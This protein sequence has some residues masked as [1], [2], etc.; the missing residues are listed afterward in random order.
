V[1]LSPAFAA[2]GR[3]RRFGERSLVAFERLA[4]F[5]FFAPFVFLVPFA[6]F[7]FCIYQPSANA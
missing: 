1:T 7:V 5:V 2:T 6:P 4:A 3:L